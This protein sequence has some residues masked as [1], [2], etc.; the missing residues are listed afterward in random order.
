MSSKSW[1]HIKN[2]TSY[3]RQG[4]LVGHH[5]PL[6]FD[7]AGTRPIRCI[8]DD[9]GVLGLWLGSQGGFGRDTPVMKDSLNARHLRFRRGARYHHPSHGIGDAEGIGQRQPHKCSVD[10]KPE[11][12]RSQG[13]TSRRYHNEGT[14]EP[15][16][17]LKQKEIIGSVGKCVRREGGGVS[18]LR[19]STIFPSNA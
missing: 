14:Q 6:K 15:L 16:H 12:L 8:G 5:S 13:K 17:P 9:F 1:P 3:R 10:L 18:I 4:W 7:P 19:I 11:G 2:K